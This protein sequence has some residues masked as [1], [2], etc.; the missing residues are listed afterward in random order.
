MVKIG[1]LI[2]LIIMMYGCG[3]EDVP[4]DSCVEKREQLELDIHNELDT[5]QTDSDFT[6]AIQSN[7]GRR[8]THSRG[9][10]SLS[11][12]YKSA[13]TS[14]MVS[15]AII[16]N[17]VKKGNLSLNDTPNDF[18]AGWDD[19]LNHQ[20]ITLN[21]LLAFTSGLSDGV[22]CLNS[23]T[24]DFEKCIDNIR[25]KNGVSTTPGSEFYYG[26]NHLQVAGLMAIKASNSGNWDALFNSFK[27]ETN[28]F[29]NASYDLPSLTNPRLAGGMHWSADEY[30]EFLEKLYKEEIL[31][32]ALINMMM[33]DQRANALSVNSPALDGM[34][35][36]WHY[37]FGVWIE[38]SSNPFDASKVTGR[39]SSPGL[40]GAYPFIDYAH[41]YYGILARE[42][43]INTYTKG[44]EL[45]KAVAPK[46][47]V[48]AEST[49]E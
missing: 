4:T 49:C 39:I 24:Y 7:D 46:L 13:S 26:P 6:L 9:D 11:K 38:S 16:L 30:L 47:E 34:G 19:T 23:D 17:V 20:G 33:S 35:E 12:Q 31:T 40:Y 27:S 14:K 15:T 48:W 41:K 45:F 22:L 37:G 44:Y 1:T 5:I 28:L 29:A 25:S 32:P 3:K 21:E 36:D 10:S 2:L 42:G 8:F 43:A 18:I